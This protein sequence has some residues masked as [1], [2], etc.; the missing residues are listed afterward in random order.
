MAITA[1]FT[2]TQ[3]ANANEC[4]ITDT[5]TGVET[6]TDRTL[7]VYKSDGTIFRPSN[8]TTDVID[9]NPTDY[10]SD[11]ITLEGL[12]KD[13]AFSVVM[14][15]TPTVVDGSSVYVTT[16]KTALTGFT[17]TAIRQRWLKAADNSR[18]E[19]NRDYVLDTYRLKIHKDAAVAAAADDDLVNAQ[20]AL[21][22]AARIIRLNKIPY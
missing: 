8:S 18:L 2:V 11:Q 15:L 9:F 14:E 16:E 19:Q 1:S 17:N 13:Y 12:D 4:V 5:T 3:G 22:M 20:K 10:P 21:K 6:F 7:T